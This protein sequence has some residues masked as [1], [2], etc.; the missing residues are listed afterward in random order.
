MKEQFKKLPVLFYPNRDDVL[1]FL[2][3]HHLSGVRKWNV[4]ERARFIAQLKLKKKMSIEDIQR[5]I[6]DKKNSAKK[7]YVCYCL[8]IIEKYDGSFDTKSNFSFLQL[9]TGQ[10]SIRE[11]NLI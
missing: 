5:T 10:S 2:G 8:K 7:T 11:R 9:A 4:Y 1:G 3:V 6:G